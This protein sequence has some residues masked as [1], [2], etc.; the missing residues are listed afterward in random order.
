MKA[1]CLL[2]AVLLA[3]MLVGCGS[4]E[5]Q[6]ERAVE[7]EL[8]SIVGPAE[9]YKVD[10]QG[11]RGATGADLVT[12][13]GTRVHPA[14]AP[15]LDRVSV[16]LANVVYNPN[17][18]GLQSISGVEG[19]VGVLGSDIAAFLEENRRLQNV[20]VTLRPPNEAVVRA[21]PEIP[22][23]QLP[24]GAPVVE[25]T[26]V[27]RGVGPIINYDVTQ[28]RAGGVTLPDPAPRLLSD[29]INPIVDLSAMPLMLQ[30]GELRVADS[31]LIADV[32]GRYTQ[33]SAS[34]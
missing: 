18:S 34:R 9:S 5:S 22:Q 11:I 4:R 6:V 33:P 32:T 25:V 1:W 27:L 23:L 29:A 30:V 20:Q 28:V 16:A 8:P 7:R 17:C 12:V 19:R 3:S 2:A 24:S 10:V 15:V 21:Q 14:G 26:G 13:S 31:T